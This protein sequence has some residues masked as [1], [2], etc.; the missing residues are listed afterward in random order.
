MILTWLS[1][2]YRR[3]FGKWP[4]NMRVKPEFAHGVFS[5]LN[6]EEIV[7]L[8]RCFEIRVVEQDAEFSVGGPPGVVR[9]D[10]SFTAFLNKETSPFH[11]ALV[12]LGLPLSKS[13]SSTDEE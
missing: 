7:R 2:E 13:T 5:G 9:Y 8:A 6:T 1:A 11:E 3:R 4:I 10:G 12:W